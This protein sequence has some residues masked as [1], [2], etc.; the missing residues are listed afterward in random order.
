MTVATQEFIPRT[1]GQ[2]E[3]FSFDAGAER[4]GAI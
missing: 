3:G 2:A 1:E 4:P